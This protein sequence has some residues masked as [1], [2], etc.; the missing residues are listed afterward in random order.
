MHDEQGYVFELAKQLGIDVRNGLPPIATDTCDE[1]AELLGWEP[2]QVV[3]ALYFCNG[4][5]YVCIV[6]PE[7]HD[8]IDP[9]DVIR[10]T[11]SSQRG[12]QTNTGR[13]GSP[14][15]CLM[16]PAPRFPCTAAWAGKSARYSY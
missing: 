2:E 9:N 10:D 11:L 3:K 1:K 12:R 13:N 15:S 5:D 16:E 4:L 8:K 7:L 6:T 14:D